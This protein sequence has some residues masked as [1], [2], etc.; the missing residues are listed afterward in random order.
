MH[1]YAEKE[2]NSQ[3]LKLLLCVEPTLYL[4][5]QSSQI[6]RQE[7]SDSPDNLEEYQEWPLELRTH[8]SDD[9]MERAL[10]HPSTGSTGMGLFVR[11]D[12]CW[13]SLTES[14]QQPEPLP[15][16]SAQSCL[17]LEVPGHR[18]LSPECTHR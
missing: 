18:A 1:S 15:A 11:G 3:E 14:W 8:K 9:L 16:R 7:L 6:T 17:L 4:V 2:L 13:L 10:T 12:F 5:T